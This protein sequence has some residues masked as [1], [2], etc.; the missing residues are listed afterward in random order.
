MS[1]ARQANVVAKG[2]VVPCPGR[3]SLAVAQGQ[4][5]YLIYVWSA[6][7]PVLR[8]FMAKPDV[9]GRLCRG[10]A[11]SVNSIFLTCS[12]G[13]AGRRGGGVRR[14]TEKPR[15]ATSGGLPWKGSGIRKGH[16][17]ISG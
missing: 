6:N 13:R 10:Y 3:C 17:S 12:D 8:Q 9:V 7:K 14:L 2:Q 11:A 4:V 5:V 15:G 16:V 1:Q